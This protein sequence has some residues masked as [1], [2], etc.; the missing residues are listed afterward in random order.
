MDFIHSIGSMAVDL[1]TLGFD[2]FGEGGSTAFQ[3]TAQEV[4]SW[5]GA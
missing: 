3:K 2:Y 4:P 1:L 5:F